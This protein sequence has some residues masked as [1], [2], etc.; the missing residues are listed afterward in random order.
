M[1]TWQ[2]EQKAF[3][4]QLWDNAPAF[5]AELPGEWLI[6]GERI[7]ESEHSTYLTL[8]RTDGLAISLHLDRHAK[9]I[10]CS[11]SVPLRP[12]LSGDGSASLR[13]YT[14]REERENAGIGDNGEASVS[15]A[16]YA[17][18]TKAA[19]RDLFRRVVQPYEKVYPIIVKEVTQR[20][21]RIQAQKD[22]ADR[23]AKTFG[24]TVHNY[25]GGDILY[26]GFPGSLPSLEVRYGGH[27]T[28]SQPLDIPESVLGD[29]FAALK[30]SEG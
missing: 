13:D 18:Q 22:T 26:V 20:K 7:R 29:L 28:T 9:K 16:R 6:K 10:N 3:S 1:T 12:G 15:L 21:A 25:R 14:T 17:G 30:K 27:I 5:I 8:V 24:G 11:P 19:A 2:E 23:I 4:D